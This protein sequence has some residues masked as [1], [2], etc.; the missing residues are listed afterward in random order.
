M[1]YSIYGL[2]FDSNLPL[3]G[4]P[5]GGAEYPDVIFAIEPDYRSGTGIAAPDETCWY[6]SDWIDETTGGPGLTIYRAVA[7][8]FRI[9][10]SDGVEFLIDGEGRRIVGR[11][12]SEANLADVACYVTGPILGFVLRLRGVIALHASAIEIG[13]KAVLL[14]GDARS[15]KS[16]TAA[17]LATMGYKVITEDVAALSLHE[18]ALTVRTGCSEVALRP[19]AVASMFGSTDAL[20]RFS[21]TWDKRRLDLMEIG[22]F[23]T[24][25]V[26]LGRVYMLTNTE[27]FPNAPCVAPMPTRDAM[28]E[29][30]ANV[31]AN[32]LLHDELRLRELDTLQQVVSSVPVKVAAT[33]AQPHLIPRFCEVLLDDL[34]SS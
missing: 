28:V 21:H 14:V 7:G 2:N 19:D 18:G 25:P 26:P 12:P 15:G 8:S 4:L 5:A 13:R 29:L 31:Y 34:H 23:A 27:G 17:V 1:L 6:E 11:A 16:T 22:A 24:E 30:L 33:G 32:R 3:P 20:P 10:Y 9:L